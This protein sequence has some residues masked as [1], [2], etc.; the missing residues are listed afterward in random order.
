MTD[1]DP[2]E[3]LSEAL[4]RKAGGFVELRFHRKRSRVLAV[5]KGRV[6]T[7][8]VTEHTGIGVRVLEDG[9]WG[10]ASTDR[11]ER[12]AID[13][14]IAVTFAVHQSLPMYA[15]TSMVTGPVRRISRL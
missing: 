14:A 7:A 8:Q 1:F 4:A 12:G 2:T 10:F 11:V 3:L 6:E 9:T 15:M 5:E 13:G